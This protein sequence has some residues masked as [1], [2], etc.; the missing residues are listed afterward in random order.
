[1][2]L[3]KCK[4][5]GHEVSNRAK[6]CPQCGAPVPKR[7]SLL[8]WLIASV[9]GLAIISAIFSPSTAPPSKQS[10]TGAPAQQSSQTNGPT[11]DKSE[12]MQEQRKGL[13]EKLI[14]QGIFQ[15]VEVP[16]SLPRVWV[17]PAFYITDFETKERSVSVVYA[18]YFD[19]TDIS[20]SVRVFDSMSGKEVGNYTPSNPG[21]KMN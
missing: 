11:I 12:K 15:K 16:G 4:E 17:R 18:Y 2:A 14:R 8:T 6:N 10:E 20:D 9:L 1:M 3:M 7:T 21:L 13:I 5:C 19:G